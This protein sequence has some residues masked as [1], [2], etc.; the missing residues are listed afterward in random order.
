M[1][2]KC[3]YSKIGGEWFEYCEP[4]SEPVKHEDEGSWL[5][6]FL[7]AVLSC[8]NYSEGYDYS[9]KTDTCICKG[10]WTSPSLWRR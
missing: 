7:C 6:E 5:G 9:Y 1:L 4:E 3:R 2:S 8:A 10:K